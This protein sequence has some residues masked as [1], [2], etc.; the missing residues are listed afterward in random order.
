M[1]YL[2]PRLAPSRIFVPGVSAFRLLGTVGMANMGLAMSRSPL[3]RLDFDNVALKKLPV[4]SS[5]EPGVR[6]VKGACFSRVKP[7]PLTKPRFVAVSHEAL[8]LLGLSGEE[9]MN[10]PLGPE[11]LSGSRVMPGSQ[12]AAHCYCGHQFGQFAGQLGDGAACYLGEVK[13]PA[14]QDPELLR[15]NPSGR[16]E[17]Q[18]KGAG[19]TPYSRQA[20]GR[21]VLRSSIREFLCSEVMYFLGVPTTRAGSVVTSN[22]R[23]IRDVYYSGNPRHERCSVVVRIAPTFLRFGS[24]EI[25]KRADEH[26]GRQGPSYGRD[27]IRGQMMDYVI[28]TF[29]P[30]IQRNHP[31]RVE[32][33][34]AFFRE[35]MLRTARLVAQWQCVGFCHGVLNTDNMSILGLTL[36]YGPYGFM[37]RFDPDFI[38]NASDNSGRYSYQAQPAICRWNLVK[39]AEALAPELPPDR[40]E[41]VMDDYLD[42]YNGFYLESMRKKLGLLKKDEPEDELLIT[43]LLQTM[44]N[45]GSDFTNT[46]RSLSQISCPTEGESEGEEELVRKATDLLL[47]QRASLEE[48]KAANKPAMDPRELA[49]LLSMAQSNPALFQMISDRTSIARQLD[50]LSKLKDLMETSQEEL[51]TQQAEEWSRWITRY[52]KRLARELQGQSDVRAAQEE[53]VR[54]MDSTNP[55]V[56]LRNYIAQ[57]AIEAAENG[58]FSEAQRVLKVL[59]KPFSLQPGLELPA[60][61]GGG[62]GGGGEATKRGERDEGEDQQQ[63]AASTSTARNPVPYD[64][65]PPAWAHEICVT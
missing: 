24:F 26:T 59:E 46:F 31:E 27:E 34:V 65:R 58:D 20:D 14:G 15:E 23:V 37:D 47:E 1:A 8:A 51:K 30:D 38:C 6:Q 39:L 56:V 17:I 50:R 21:K 16:W 33:N 42:L 54:V 28:E 52:R 32:R 61:V 36:D 44:H 9:V 48:L 43:E 62:G 22:S 10:D 5:E 4:D 2:G 7:Q 19:S 13:V 57:N 45:T 3:E 41:A 40:A 64:S 29:Y 53:R 18:V 49:M 12:P 55:R 25:F 11:Y 60:W 35:V 63:E